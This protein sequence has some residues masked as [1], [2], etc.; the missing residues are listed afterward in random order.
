MPLSAQPP[1]IPLHP[2]PLFDTLK[3]QA[4]RQ[5]SDLWVVGG[6]VRDALLGRAGLDI[7]LITSG[8]PESLG[9]AIARAL[10][11]NYVLLDAE[12]G[13]TRV[14]LA[15]GGVIDLARLQGATIADDLFNRD[16]TI[17]A[18][19]LP[20]VQGGTAVEAPEP[21]DPTGGLRDLE[22]RV[23]RAISDD[24][25]VA[26]P[27]RMIRVFR[28]AAVLDFT[29]DFE[30]LQWVDTYKRKL[31]DVAAERTTAELLKIL[32]LPAAF[33]WI[34]RLFG[35][36]V[37]MVLL[38]E[39]NMLAR[40][41]GP[42]MSGQ[43][44]ALE[45]ARCLEQLPATLGAHAA[46]V[47]ADLDRDLGGGA[48]PWTV[49]KLA[50]LLHE[51]G[52]PFCTTYGADQSVSYEGYEAEGAKRVEA[53]AN[54]LK[55]SAKARDFLTRLVKLQRLPEALAK[56]PHDPVALY[57]FFQA[58][59]DT[60][61]GLLLL[62]LA[63]QRAAHSPA[64]QEL[65]AALPALLAAYFRPDAAYTAPRRLID[66]KDLMR[67]LGLKPGKQIG[68]LLEAIVEAQLRGEIDTRD[69]AIAWASRH[70]PAEQASE[71]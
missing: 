16:L 39:F 71:R 44:H 18:I 64:T 26:D 35:M 8:D 57:R 66:G 55:L 14:V 10:G 30:T 59:G 25:L 19:A 40:L 1:S 43:G 67:E 65:A 13:I 7:D 53:I 24:N 27:V 46:A 48:T 58:A 70:L 31:L 62:N 29:I 37:L 50:A 56:T 52:K 60:S 21:L 17:N 5:A 51:V 61:V 34:E 38:P 15:S 69:G 42:R 32:A 2:T 41:Q 47:Q 23:V 36:G 49:L 20:L 12:F 6:Y 68:M 33:L 22:R 4:A 11:G 9:K 3:D 54:R 63:L 45:T 28:F